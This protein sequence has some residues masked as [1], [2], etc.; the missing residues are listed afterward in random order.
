MKDIN[1]TGS[2]LIKILL[3]E[4]NRITGRKTIYLLSVVLPVILFLLVALIYKNGVVRNLPVAVYDADNSTL[5]RMLSRSVDASSSMAVTEHVNSLDELKTEFLKGHIQGAFYFPENMERDIKR[6]TGSSM[7]IFKNT[8]S[9]IVGNMI[10]KDG[11]TIARTVSGGALLK[12]LRSKGLSETQAMNVINPIRIETQSLYNPEYNYLQY[13]IPGLLTAMFQMIIMISAVLIIS[14]EFTHNTFGELVRISGG[15]IFTIILGKALPHLVLHTVTALGIIGIIFPMFSIEIGG[16]VAFSLAFIEYF[17][18]TSFFL[19][20]LLS[21]SFHEQLFATEVALFINTPAFI[22]SGFTFPLWGMPALHNY[23]AQLIPFT[24]F[25]SGFLKIY[26]MG[27]PIKYVAPEFFRLSIFLVISLAASFIVLR[28]RVN[29]FL[30][31]EE[32]VV[33]EVK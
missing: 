31:N 22:F 32:P 1:S 24:H 13:L 15:N 5:S 33:E 11:M 21:C 20:F 30:S 19:G 10:Y 29:S 17:I 6:G 28:F 9:L 4:I 3:R 8:S 16:S 12:K 14:S 23:F 7:V 25:L 26:Q 27:T 2:P 18:L